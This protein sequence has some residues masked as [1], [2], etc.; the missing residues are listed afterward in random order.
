MQGIDLGVFS[1][2]QIVDIVALNRLV[3]KR[4]ADEQDDAK[5]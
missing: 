5:H 2:R 1:L 3:E 4:Q